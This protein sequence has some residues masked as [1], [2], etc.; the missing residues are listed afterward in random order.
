[1]VYFGRGS[2]FPRKNFR[3]SNLENKLLKSRNVIK[4]LLIERPDSNH[5]NS[6]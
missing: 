1:M 3:N 6:K 5:G 2:S 4:V